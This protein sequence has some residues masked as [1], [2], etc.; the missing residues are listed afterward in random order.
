MRAITEI[1]AKTANPMGKTESVVPGS[2]NG[3]GL[4]DA[5]ESA[6]EVPEGSVDVL[7]AEL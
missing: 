4:D 7:D 2:L 1:P 6:A 5:A 3:G